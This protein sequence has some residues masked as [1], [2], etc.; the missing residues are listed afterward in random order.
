MMK[1]EFLDVKKSGILPIKCMLPTAVLDL[2][3]VA[4][5]DN[6]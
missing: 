6:M 4:V 5:D 3:F 2:K 1:H